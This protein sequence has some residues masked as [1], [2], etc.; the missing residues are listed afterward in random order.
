MRA[1]LLH[2]IRFRRDHRFV[3]AH[4]SAMVDGEL[5][6]ADAERIALHTLGCP[7]CH[8][9]L[10]SLRAVVRGLGALR[11]PPVARPVGDGVL[12]A[13]RRSDCG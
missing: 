12:D 3:M 7:R 6:A 13:L 9:M 10:E 8:E 2:P 4:A 11:R 5:S 1:M